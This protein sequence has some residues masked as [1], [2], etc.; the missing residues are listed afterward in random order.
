GLAEQEYMQKEYTSSLQLLEWLVHIYPYDA[1]ILNNLASLHI[2][3][4]NKDSAIKLLKR[5]LLVQPDFNLAQRNLAR[6][7]TQ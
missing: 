6:L 4:G 7:Q 5:A 3:A 2:V 1:A